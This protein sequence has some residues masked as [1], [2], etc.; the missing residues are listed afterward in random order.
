MAADRGLPV[1]VR[2]GTPPYTWIA[3]GAPVL[4]GVRVEQASLPNLGQGFSRI[5]VIDAA[6]LS[7]RVTVRLD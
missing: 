7:A 5:S 6:G 1:K 3:N 4:T 2:G